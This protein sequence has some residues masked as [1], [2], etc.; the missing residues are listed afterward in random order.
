MNYQSCQITEE[1]N[2]FPFVIGSKPSRMR[3]MQSK[4]GI[5][6]RLRA[7]AFA[8]IQARDGFLWGVSHFKSI[9]ET[10]RNYWENF[11]VMEERHSQLLLDRAKELEVNLAERI[12]SNSLIR[13]FKAAESPELFFYL[14]ATA[15]E[16]GMELGLE[17]LKPMSEFDPVSAEVFKICAEEEVEHIKTAK[18][19]LTSF[20]CATL[21]NQAILIKHSM[22]S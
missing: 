16:R 6:D 22:Y 3:S 8:E 11:A 12:V 2:W 9:N 18:A 17:M 7:V 20:D 14:M 19:L 4:E 5:G 10:W 15:E 1:T 13:M 21:K